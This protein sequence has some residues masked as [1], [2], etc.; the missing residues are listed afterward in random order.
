MGGM[1]AGRSAFRLRPKARADLEGI[2]LYTAEHWSPDQADIY[3]N[4]IVDILTG[5]ASGR[6]QG[7]SAEHVREGYLKHPAGSHVIYFR[8]A[9]YGIEIVRILHGRMDVERHL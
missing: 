7:R 4:R 9:D 2:W 5:L 1:P 3:H 8:P 6:I